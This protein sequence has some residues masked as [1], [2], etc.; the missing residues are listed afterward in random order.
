LSG[1][2]PTG[3]QSNTIITFPLIIAGIGFVL[4]MLKIRN[5]GE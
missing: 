3:I 2:V 1:S 4:R 5:D